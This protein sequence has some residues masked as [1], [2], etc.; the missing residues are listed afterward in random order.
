MWSRQNQGYAKPHRY[1]SPVYKNLK[2]W[3]LVYHTRPGS[4]EVELI[5]NRLF[6]S[7]KK[8]MNWF[9]RKRVPSAYI[10]PEAIEISGFTLLSLGEH[11]KVPTDL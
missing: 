9:N 7:K 2:L 4:Q 11:H 3:A 10:E 5:T 6:K 1:L 8:A